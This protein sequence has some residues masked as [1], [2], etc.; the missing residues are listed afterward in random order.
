MVRCCT[1][2]CRAT[3]DGRPGEALPAGWFFVNAEPGWICPQCEQRSRVGAMIT[4][5]VVKKAPQFTCVRCKMTAASP[6]VIPNGHADGAGVCSNVKACQRRQHIAAAK[7]S[8]KAA[9]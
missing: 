2:N 7:K 5:D 3:F 9:T 4:T 1:K 8:A 6:M